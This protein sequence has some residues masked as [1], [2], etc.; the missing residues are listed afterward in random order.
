MSTNTRIV[1]IVHTTC[2]HIYK[3]INDKYTSEVGCAGEYADRAN[4]ELFV[5]VHERV[6]HVH[7]QIFQT[8]GW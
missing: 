1:C 5:Y 6:V 3:K 8:Q 7:H 2:D 4:S